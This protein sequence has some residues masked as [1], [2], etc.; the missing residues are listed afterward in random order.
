M[1]RLRQK[2]NKREELAFALKGATFV[3][4]YRA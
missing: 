3:E 2:A 1:K 4:D